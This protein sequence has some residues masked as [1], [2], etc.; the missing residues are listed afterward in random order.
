[1]IDLE[2]LKASIDLLALAGHDTELKHVATSGGGEWAGPCPFCGG[3]DRFRIQPGARRWMCH[4]CTDAKWQDA[5]AYIMRRDNLDFKA[6]LEALGGDAWRRLGSAARIQ[7]PPTPADQPPGDKWQAAA[8]QIIDTCAAKLWQPEGEKALAWLR[9]RRGL[10]EETI[11]R[12]RLGVW[13]GGEL[14]GLKV[15]RGIVIPCTV[16]GVIWYLKVRISPEL[17]K[18]AGINTCV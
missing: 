5:I 4:N 18:R 7:P 1:M 3:K 13:P 2:A 11:K 10:S 17:I 8:H 6:A 15:W 9:T 12:R 14:A 16:A